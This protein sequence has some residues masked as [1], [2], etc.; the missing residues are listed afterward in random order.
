MP[1]RYYE[2]TSFDTATATCTAAAWVEHHDV[3]PILTPADVMVLLSRVAVVFAVAWGWK[4][5][6]RQ[7]RA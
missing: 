1:T 7:T 2:C 6:S 5:L 3:F 4:F